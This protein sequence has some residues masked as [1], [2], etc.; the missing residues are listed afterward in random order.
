MDYIENLRFEQLSLPFKED[1]PIQEYLLIPS[2]L[3]GFHNTDTSSK[4]LPTGRKSFC[5]NGTLALPEERICPFCGGSRLHINQHLPKTLKHLPVGNGISSIHFQNAQ[6]LCMDCGRTHMQE[7]PFKSE[8]H[9]ITRELEDYIC[10]LLARHTLTNKEISELTGVGQNIVKAI[11]KRRLEGLYVVDGKLRRPEHHAQFL[12]IDEFKLHNGHKYATH[13]I[14]MKT[15]HI[16]WISE[17]KK[18]QVVYDFIEHVGLEWMSHV[19]AVA[20]DMNSNFQEAFTEKCPH[21]R[22]VF[23]YF[24]IFKN[25]ND[26]V[27]SEIRKDEQKRLEDAGDYEAARNL[28][29]SRHILMSSRATLERK[30]REA[31]EGKVLR[32]ESSIFPMQEVKR[33]NIGYMKRYESILEKNRLLFV[34][35]LIKEMLQEAFSCQSEHLMMEYINRIMA[36]CLERA[37]GEE[38]RNRHLMWF[39]KLLASHL[40]GILAHATYRI[41]AGKI[42]GINNKIKT[43]RRQAYGYPDDEYFFLKL[44]DMSRH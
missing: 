39:R 10:I 9:F 32:K 1:A 38:E 21:L 16:L 42:E 29:R 27:V 5:M 33:R 26:K 22:V 11:D 23:D 14:D 8:H 28:K 41:S 37:P 18:K 6:Y 12:G 44:I 31:N 36:L 7:I 13:I 25:F 40:D 19:E 30:D 43:L 20:L 4:I 35:D 34:T 2:S 24:H 17:G 3:T 15:G